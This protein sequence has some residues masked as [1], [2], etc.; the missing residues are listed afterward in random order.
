MARET[1]TLFQVTK[2]FPPFSLRGR[3]NTQQAI[4]FDVQSQKVTTDDLKVNNS[5]TKNVPNKAKTPVFFCLS[6]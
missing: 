3:N 2:I 1:K 4:K 6:F 5:A